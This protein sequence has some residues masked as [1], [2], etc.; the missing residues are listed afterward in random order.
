MTNRSTIRFLIF[1]FIYSVLTMF[2]GWN[3]W[4]WLHFEFGY[5]GFWLYAL[6][7]VLLS[8]SYMISRFLTLFGLF[9]WLGSY[10]FGVLQFSVVILP[11]ADI[12]A[13]IMLA[14]G[15]S[16]STAITWVGFSTL[17]LFVLFIAFGTFNTYSPIV[18]TYSIVIPKNANHLS[19]LRIAMVSDM[20]FGNLS[21]LSH[22]RRMVKKINELTPDIILFLGDL[23]DDDPAPF[24]RK[25]MGDIMKQLSTPLGVY[26]VLGNHDYYGGAV[27]ELI[28]EMERI[29]VRILLDESLKV[30]NSFYL[31]GRHDKSQRNRL[32]FEALLTAV[33]SNLP[34]IVMDHQPTELKQAEQHGVDLILSGHTHRGQMFPNHLLT[35]RL[36]ELDWGYLQKNQLHAIVTSGFGFWGPPLRIGSRSEIVQIDVTFGSGAKTSR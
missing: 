23:V 12:I 1:L 10:W 25:K 11:L 20:H 36:F 28:G 19:N 33:D 29:G 34:I 4:V 27:P 22:L 35:R 21:G 5:E 13:L 8:Y 14:A 17:V 9:R 15:V 7:V 6:S 32:P 16:T 26:G 3:G 24:I 31:V 2:I 30:D 18:R